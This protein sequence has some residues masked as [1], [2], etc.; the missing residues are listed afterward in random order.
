VKANVE[1]RK[2][3]NQEIRKSGNQ[4]IRKSGNQVHHG[5]E[6]GAYSQATGQDSEQMN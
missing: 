4:E 5:L 6:P 2:S 1:I 3:G